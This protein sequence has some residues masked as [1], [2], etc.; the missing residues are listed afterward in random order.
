MVWVGAVDDD[1]SSLLI[2]PYGFKCSRSGII[3]LDVL[4]LRKGHLF[5]HSPPLFTEKFGVAGVGAGQ[6]LADRFHVVQAAR[7]FSCQ[8]G[9]ASWWLYGKR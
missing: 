1:F 9:R 6:Q 8:V 2:L 4:D 3:W 5:G 7:S